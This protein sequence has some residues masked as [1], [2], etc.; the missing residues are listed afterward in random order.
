[1]NGVNVWPLRPRG[2]INRLAD[3]GHQRTVGNGPLEHAVTALFG[4][5]HRR[6]SRPNAGQQ[7]PPAVPTSRSQRLQQVDA[8]NLAHVHIDNDARV[9]ARLWIGEQRS[10]AQRRSRASIA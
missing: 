6:G 5:V 10:A 3:R 1:M 2:A 4:G 9:I 8:V 7:Y